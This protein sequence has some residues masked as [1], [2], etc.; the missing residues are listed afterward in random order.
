MTYIAPFFTG[1]EQEEAPRRADKPAHSRQTPQRTEDA[2][3]FCLRAPAETAVGTPL[4]A[5]A[6]QN[7][8][9][10]TQGKAGAARDEPPAGV[11]FLRPDQLFW[12]QGARISQQRSRNTVIRIAKFIK[13]YGFSEY[14]TVR[15][16]EGSGYPPRYEIVEGEVLWQAACLAGAAQIPCVVLPSQSGEERQKEAILAQIRQKTGDF[17][18]EAAAFQRLCEQYGMS[19]GEIARRLGLSTSAVANKLRL[20]QLSPEEQAALL[21]AGLT[22]RHARALLRLRS[23][24]LRE[25]AI[26]MAKQAHPTVATCEQWIEHLLRSPEEADELLLRLDSPQKEVKNTLESAKFTS[27]EPPNAPTEALG[28]RQPKTTHTVKTVME[29]SRPRGI[30][31]QK[32]AMQS[33][34]P[35]YNSIERTLAIFRKSGRSAV[36]AHEEGPEG[37]LITITIP[38]K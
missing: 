19:R 32:F 12:P 17:F 2:G 5:H 34:Q 8:D 22:E 38:P 30:I 26:L 6:R 21:A 29:P 23:P 4:L 35:L 9:S 7:S 37:I 13:K 20:L 25:K 10:I 16:E 24:A 33:L 3:D 31:P 27:N 11:L 36:M 28:A 15:G 14:L 1:S 18:A